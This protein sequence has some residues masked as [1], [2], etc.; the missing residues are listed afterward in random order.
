MSSPV[1]TAARYAWSSRVL[2]W[3]MAVMVLA[4]LLIGMAMVASLPNYHWLLSIHRPLGILV[5]LFVVVR[6]VNRQV[7]RL[8]PF[9]E[10]MSAIERAAATWSERLLYALMFLMPLI[11]WGMLSAARYPIVMFGSIHLPPILPYS[12]WL[13]TV[14]RTSHAIFAYL[15]FLTFMAHLSAVLFHTLV[16]RD[17]LLR[18][19]APTPTL[20]PETRSSGA[21]HPARG[22]T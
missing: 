8:P 1:R 3:L 20:E 7:T 14:L 4:M 5:L 9:P 12:M 19:M 18:R 2:H 15:L 21:W 17:R 10:T 22:R 6:F 16:L 13:Y 11:G